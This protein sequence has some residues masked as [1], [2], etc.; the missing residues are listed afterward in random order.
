MI[1]KIK[2]SFNIKS[3]LTLWY[4]LIL[5]VVLTLFSSMVYLK[6][7]NELYKEVREFIHIESQQIISELDYTDNHLQTERIFQNLKDNLDTKNIQFS[8]YNQDGL[9]ILGEKQGDILPSVTSTNYFYSIFEKD[10][11][12]WV[13]V[14]MPR[15]KDG[16]VTGYVRLARSLWHEENTLDKLLTMF[17]FGIPITL[18]I[19]L[20]GGYFL[21]LR[22][23][24][25]IDRIIKTTQEISHSNLSCRL[26]N[27]R[28]NS[29]D[30]VARLTQTLNQLLNRLEN[31]FNRQKQFSADASHELRT[32]IAVISAQVEEAL[33]SSKTTEDYREALLLIKKQTDH[34]SH[35]VKQ[36]LLLS[37]GDDNNNQLER[38]I[39]NLTELIDVIVEEIEN[40]SRKKSIK[41][42][43]KVSEHNIYINADQSRIT[44]LLLNLMDN[45]IEYSNENSLIEIRLNRI[46]EDQVEIKVI[47]DG[48][49]IPAEHLDNIFDRFYQADKSR[50]RKR[51]G[52]G[53]G[54]S[55]CHWI[56]ESHGGSI[57]VTSK[58]NQGSIFTVILPIDQT[59][60]NN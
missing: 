22:A 45:A 55:I 47:D 43:K 32:P 41:I 49:G 15:E 12:K 29:N 36:L 1:T 53:L 60:K 42:N 46:N 10:G 21:A 7:K 13:V 28:N 51:G 59:G 23:F 11:Q 16:I 19:S 57:K 4:V 26:V 5:A 38:E 52:T 50:W 56:V 25:P 8:I 17:M 9:L 37:R 6:M 40:I 18:I 44:E 31:A 30:E 20:G 2:G 58:I 24:T 35:L 54:L 27:D 14:N 33:S 48:S 39:F 34:M 3:T